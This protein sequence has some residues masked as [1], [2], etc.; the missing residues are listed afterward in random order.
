MAI[1][2]SVV[3]L[4]VVLV[5]IF[6]RNKALKIPHALVCILLGFYLASTDLAPT[7]HDGISATADMISGLNP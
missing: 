5:V 4:F 1:S 7:I 3:L 2:I 6:I